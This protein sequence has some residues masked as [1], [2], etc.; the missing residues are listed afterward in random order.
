MNTGN[1]TEIGEMM[2]LLWNMYSE[3]EYVDAVTLAESI[4]ETEPNNIN[5]IG[6]LALVY[7]KMAH[8]SNEAGDIDGEQEYLKHAFDQYIRIVEID[9]D[10]LAE[11]TKADR[12][13]LKLNSNQSNSFSEKLKAFDFKIFANN[14]KE[15]WNEYSQKE[16]FKTAFITSCGVLFFLVMS[17]TFLVANSN[18]RAAIEAEMKKKAAVQDEFASSV[19]PR[20]NYSEGSN[21]YSGGNYY[22]ENYNGPTLD[23]NYESPE[24]KA[25][26][27]EESQSKMSNSRSLDPNTL[28]DPGSRIKRGNVNNSNSWGNNQG[29]RN[30]QNYSY[31][32]TEN[33]GLS[34][35]KLPYSD[36]ELRPSDDNLQNGS[37]GNGRESVSPEKSSNDSKNE[38]KEKL[39]D[40]S[41]ISVA[42]GF[43]KTAMR[44]HDSGNY[45][46]MRKNAL[47][48]K[49]IYQEEMAKGNKVDLCKY[50]ISTIN[51]L[52]GD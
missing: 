15:V 44:D 2:S 7:E 47:E 50:N 43:L 41:R 5:A 24:Y 35:F 20:A 23:F 27:Q 39:S 42:N 48:A 22:G 18:K 32:E 52:L 6:V 12:I 3:G 36:F 49:R 33:N 45:N 40:S 14:T 30:L 46:E 10:N 29:N 11:Q 38:S 34:G 4:L 28:S 51:T 37:Q 8:A 26:K 1:L 16:W 13:K 17:I 19:V 21:N 31:S 25:Q 9:P